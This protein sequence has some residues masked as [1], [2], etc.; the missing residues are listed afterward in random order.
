MESMKVSRLTNY[1]SVCAHAF[2]YE[3]SGE[4]TKKDYYNLSD[5]YEM[6]SP[7]LYISVMQGMYIVELVEAMPTGRLIH[8]TCKYSTARTNQYF[9]TEA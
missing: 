5:N 3:S 8:L 9:I 4:K 1:I 6:I 2:K 7:R